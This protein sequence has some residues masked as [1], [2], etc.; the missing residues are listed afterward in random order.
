MNRIRFVPIPDNMDVFQVT[1]FEA[2]LM[3]DATFRSNESVGE[4]LAFPLL[5]SYHS[6]STDC[7]IMS[8]IFAKSNGKL[9]STTQSSADNLQ[10]SRGV[11]KLRK[12]KPLS[13]RPIK[14]L[15]S[16]L[17][18]WSISTMSRLSLA[19]GRCS[20]LRPIA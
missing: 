20:L 18:D 8:R 2:V 10:P 12:A 7:F 16:A 1:Q 15:R 13:T 9:K 14:P 6:V 4:V 11:S 3:T 17:P 5:L 19:A